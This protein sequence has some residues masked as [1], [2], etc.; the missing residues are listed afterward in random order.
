MD[1]RC[2]AQAYF[3]RDEARRLLL[4]HLLAPR[5]V[6]VEATGHE[7]H[8]WTGAASWSRGCLFNCLWVVLQFVH[9]LLRGALECSRCLWVVFWCLAGVVGAAASPD[10]L[11]HPPFAISIR[12]NPSAPCFEIRTRASLMLFQ[13]ASADCRENH[14]FGS[15]LLARL[16]WD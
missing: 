3:P 14:V 5:R 11:C 6:R 2:T 12:E 8:G 16:A 10:K 15:G 7:L 1:R 13:V 4:E 9:G